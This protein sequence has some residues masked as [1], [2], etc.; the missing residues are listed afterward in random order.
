MH[1]LQSSFRTAAKRLLALPLS[2]TLCLS[3]AACN[4][5]TPSQPGSSPQPSASTSPSAEPSIIPTDTPEATPTPAETGSATPTPAATPTPGSGSATPAPT[6]T[7]TP[8]ASASSSAQF[9]GNASLLSS[10]SISP[11]R[12][13]L[14]S[15]GAT[16]QFIVLAQ[17]S[18]GNFIDPSKLNLSWSVSQP[19]DFSIT[20][21]GL[22]KATDTSGYAVVTVRETSKSLLANA[23]VQIGGGGSGGGGGGGGGSTSGTTSVNSVVTFE[24]I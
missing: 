18:S 10:L 14:S 7:P 17:D 9:P 16:Y 13:T 6:A 8:Q 12:G 19:D 20:S 24:G 5:T 11:S 23:D 4:Q 1:Y 3:L 22:I 15:E 21:S 2:L